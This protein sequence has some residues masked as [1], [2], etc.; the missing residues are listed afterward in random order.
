M[1]SPEY[2]VI[3]ME[4]YPRREHFRYF[5][6]LKNPH[7]SVTVEID[8]TDTVSFC[9]ANG[10]SFFLTFM[11]AAALAADDIP[12]FRRRIRDGGIIEYARCGTSHTESTVAGPY[13][14]CALRHDMPFGDYIRYAEE[15]R[16]VCRESGTLTEDPD[17]DS[18]YFVSSLP[19][20]H[21]T[22]FS[23][24]T[25]DGD[26]SNPRLNWGKF[27]EDSRGRLM[28]PVTVLVNHA[29]A[30]GE[31]LAAF[32]GRLEQRLTALIEEGV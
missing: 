32:F 12:E 16:R 20:L 5:R 15:K 29:L 11:H 18:M 25:G 24:P 17:I 7:V 19:W 4:T 26:D 8:V 27:A 13:C 23:Q 22:Q 1:A 21:Y 28:M 9:R 14:Y 10:I 31:H 6:S 3:D 2:R 30:D